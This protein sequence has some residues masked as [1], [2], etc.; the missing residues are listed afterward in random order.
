MKAKEPHLEYL[1]GEVDQKG[2]F[3]C[4]ANF[5]DK[6]KALLHWDEC[7]KRHKKIHIQMIERVV[8]HNIITEAYPT[9]MFN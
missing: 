4:W 2:E 6:T 9:C 8:T 7:L 1:V 5:T 3:W